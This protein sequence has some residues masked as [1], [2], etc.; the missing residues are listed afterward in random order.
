MKNTLAFLILLSALSTFGQDISAELPAA[1]STLYREANESLNNG[2]KKNAILI[3]D[4]VVDFYEQEGRQ[5]ELAESYLGM[6][7][8]FALN[9][10]YPESIRYHKK[11]LR[12]HHRYKKKESS[13]EIELNL[14][15]AY[16][17]AGKDRKAKR[18]LKSEFHG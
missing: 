15:M 9:G 17:L 6:A 10:N 3:Y 4:K 8:S 12:A 1:P 14:G 7:L 5:A 11:A 18:Y 16:Q 13:L 2:D